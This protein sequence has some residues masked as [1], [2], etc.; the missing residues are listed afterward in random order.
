MLL[1]RLQIGHALLKSRGFLARGGGIELER[2]AARFFLLD[3]RLETLSF[4]GCSAKSVEALGRKPALLGSVPLR[5]GELFARFAQLAFQC[6]RAI[7][8]LCERFFRAIRRG[9][10]RGEWNL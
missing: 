6:R 9:L 7:N 1:R 8:P 10:A 3:L 2:F 5:L 4:S